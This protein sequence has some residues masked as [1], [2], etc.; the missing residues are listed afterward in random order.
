MVAAGGEVFNIVKS[1]GER[2]TRSTAPPPSTVAPTS[3]SDLVLKARVSGVTGSIEEQLQLFAEGKITQ[4]QLVARKGAIEGAHLE[5]YT[6]FEE[7]G[8]TPEETQEIIVARGGESAARL[9]STVKQILTMEATG[10]ISHEQSIATIEHYQEKQLGEVRNIMSGENL[11]AGGSG[12]SIGYRFEEKPAESGP[13]DVNVLL[14]EAEG[15]TV[16]GPLPRPAPDVIPIDREH[17]QREAAFTAPAL[18]SYASSLPK[19]DAIYSAAGGPVRPVEPEIFTHIKVQPSTVTHLGI[20]MTRAQFEA[21]FAGIPDS[22]VP[23]YS[24]V[25]LLT[26]LPDP[27]DFVGIPGPAS[28]RKPGSISEK[29]QTIFDTK[30]KEFEEGVVSFEVG[31]RKAGREL[32]AEAQVSM[33]EGDVGKALLLGTTAFATR[34]GVG[35]IEGSTFLVRPLAWQKAAGGIYEG[36]KGVIEDPGA[37]PGGIQKWAGQVAR[38]PGSIVEFAGDIA[39]GFAI[40]QIISTIT[41]PTTKVSRLEGVDIDV[42]STTLGMVDEVDQFSGKSVKVVQFPEA[43][44]TPTVTKQRIPRVVADLMEVELDDFRGSGKLLGVAEE[45]GLIRLEKIDVPAGLLDDLLEGKAVTVDAPLITEG[46]PRGLGD[47]GILAKELSDEITIKTGG[48]RIQIDEFALLE[49]AED[50]SF[51]LPTTGKEVIV[52]P[53]SDLFG[54]ESTTFLEI[55]EGKVKF[56]GPWFDDGVKGVLEPGEHRFDVKG[57]ILDEAPN[58]LDDLPENIPIDPGVGPRT[59]LSKTFGGGADVVQES[60]IKEITEGISPLASVVTEPAVV[61][62][63]VALGVGLGATALEAPD[64]I[65]SESV[66]SLMGIGLRTTG[67]KGVSISGVLLGSK[68]RGK[69]DPFSVPDILGGAET[70][71][72]KEAT[73]IPIFDTTE[74]IDTPK[75]VPP[76]VI[77]APDTTIDV[78]TPVILSPPKFHPPK[79]I[80]IVRPG[81]TPDPDPV[82]PRV[83]PIMN[84]LPDTKPKPL[85]KPPIVAPIVIPEIIPVLDVPADQIQEPVIVPIQSVV[86]KQRTV[87]T[88]PLFSILGT[89]RRAFPIRGKRPPSRRRRR[90]PFNLIGFEE[91]IYPLASAEA[92]LGGTPGRRRRGPSRPPGRGPRNM[93]DLILGRAPKPRKRKRKK[94]KPRKRKKKR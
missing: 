8:A 27:V 18:K 85:P 21:D 3:A 30:I 44:L 2:S 84:I 93:S 53:P 80:P 38:D 37:V 72:P 39:A 7:T 81:L 16:Y 64:P 87:R 73:I 13:I 60:I 23:T 26:E 14:Q 76:I 28:A 22:E 45:G 56:G 90:D 5:W 25:P 61:S 24:P 31:M 49:R 51:D 75:P 94:A 78:V 65:S 47:R 42:K 17:Q 34:A 10:D 46:L 83:I 1:K 67:A 43:E 79:V 48:Q 71:P 33:T 68:G 50:A 91:R 40:S 88:P 19:P 69:Q 4:E 66:Q 86:Q 57:V 29:I 63:G 52:Y 74:I 77:V 82:I 92:L 55:P 54:G 59:P 89:K 20:T 58:I 9:E 41:G 62:K 6:G 32:G 15:E 70:G 12:L 35:I 11:L 36:T